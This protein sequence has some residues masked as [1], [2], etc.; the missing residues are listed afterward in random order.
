M[1]GRIKEQGEMLKREL[2]LI[3]RELEELE[4]KWRLEREELETG[5]GELE[6]RIARIGEE[7]RDRIKQVERRIEVKESE[8]RRKNLILKEVKVKERK[9][10][11]A[12]EEIFKDINIKVNI[13]KTETLRGNVER[14]TETIWVKLHNEEQRRDI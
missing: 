2:E 10:K 1:R 3:K 9:R 11:A 14:G 7:W 4:E 12:R 13:E 6:R 8:E 5:I